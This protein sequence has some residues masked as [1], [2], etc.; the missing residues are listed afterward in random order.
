MIYLFSI[1]EFQVL[2]AAKGLSSYYG[3]PAAAEIRQEDIYLSVYQMARAGILK[4]DQQHLVI[5]PPVSEYM[6]CI[7]SSPEVLVIDRGQ[8]RLP[9]QC[10]YQSSSL[11]VS[12]EHSTTEPGTL[13]MTGMSDSEWIEQLTALN[14][15]PEANLKED[16]GNF[17]YMEYWQQHISPELQELLVQE[18][19]CDSSLLLACEQVYSVFSF[20]NKENGNMRSRFIILSLPLEYCVVRQQDGQENCF[21]LYKKELIEDYL[22]E[23]EDKTI[24]IS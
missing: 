12:L 21:E 15:L 5:Q 6:D 7:R 24:D 20:R 19:R 11:I 18:S 17:D 23:W 2:A 1:Q 8:Y 14:M 10:V 13:C 22:S 9:S 4:P 3:F 16:L